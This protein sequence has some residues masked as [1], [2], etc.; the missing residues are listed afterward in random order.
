M[1]ANTHV[2]LPTAVGTVDSDDSGGTAPHQFVHTAVEQRHHDCKND[3]RD[4]ED[5]YPGH[6]AGVGAASAAVGLAA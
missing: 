1:Q 5:N 2:L 6:K 4:A 3:H